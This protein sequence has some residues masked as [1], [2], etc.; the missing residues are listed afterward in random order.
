M[1]VQI[2]PTIAIPLT[3]SAH[4]LARC[5][6]WKQI[7][8]KR[9]KQV[10]LNTLAIHAVKDYLGWLDIATNWPESESAN[11]IQQ[12]LCNSADLVISGKGTIECRPVLPDE[13][14]CT[15]PEDTWGDRLAYIAVRLNPELTEGTL[16]GYLSEVERYKTPLNQLHSL[17]TLLDR[18]DEEADEAILLTQWLNHA[19][20]AGWQTLSELLGP[21]EPQFAFNFRSPASQSNPSSS[22]ATIKRG[23][24]LQL[25][26]DRDPVGLF[27]GIEPS[28]REEFDISVE[29]SPTGAERHLPKELQLSILDD[30][31]RVV[32]HASSRGTKSIQLDFS[33]EVGDRFS[34]KVTLGE[35]GVTE[36]FAI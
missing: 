10:Y 9:A 22:A 17:D 26:P 36:F 13:T 19:F 20:D 34:I 2:N 4:Q 11:P 23:K 25:Q 35:I 16:L 29:L 6:A 8:P 12:S 7:D 18:L 24:H 31:D 30:E 32:M 1:N 3:L 33:A 15:I 27:V 28:D 5:H 21:D 14:T